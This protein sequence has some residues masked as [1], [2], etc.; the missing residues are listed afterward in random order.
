MGGSKWRKRTSIR[1]DLIQY[2]Y[3]A[4]SRQTWYLRKVAWVWLQITISGK[5]CNA[6]HNTESN[7]IPC[8]QNNDERT[9]PKVSEGNNNLTGEIF[10]ITTQ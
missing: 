9:E 2:D 4:L 10:W 5:D 1:T 3:Q 7:E 6:M 8:E